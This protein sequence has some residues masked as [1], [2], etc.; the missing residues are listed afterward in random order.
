MAVKRMNYYKECEVDEHGFPTG[1]CETCTHT[2]P[3]LIST[4]NNS[5]VI[6]ICNISDGSCQYKEHPLVTFMKEKYANG[7]PIYPYNDTPK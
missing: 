4:N 7:M 3:H 5:E 6:W 2:V 1:K